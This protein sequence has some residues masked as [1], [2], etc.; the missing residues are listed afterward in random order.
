MGKCFWSKDRSSKSERRYRLVVRL[1]AIKYKEDF[2]CYLSSTA[3]LASRPFH[4]HSRPRILFVTSLVF[5][6]FGVRTIE[7]HNFDDYLIRSSTRIPS[8]GPSSGYALDLLPLGVVTK[9]W[10]IGNC[11]AFTPIH[12]VIWWIVEA[13]VDVLEGRASCVQLAVLLTTHCGSYLWLSLIAIEE[14]PSLATTIGSWI[15][16]DLE[17]RP[18]STGSGSTI[19]WRRMLWWK[20][21]GHS[22]D[23]GMVVR[24]LESM[25]TWCLGEWWRGSWNWWCFDVRMKFIGHVLGSCDQIMWVVM[26]HDHDITIAFPFGRELCWALKS[27]VEECKPGGKTSQPMRWSEEENR[28]INENILAP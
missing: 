22:P 2:L 3:S 1:K 24:I 27:S 4:S 18:P 5:Q 20:R 11:S 7:P 10:L 15:G 25:M 26:S 12:R 8:A 17:V 19:G 14:T 23:G 16:V 6:S 13:D 9:L 28:V 21:P